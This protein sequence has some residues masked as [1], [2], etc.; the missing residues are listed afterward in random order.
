MATCGRCQ[1]EITWAW[2][3]SDH[4]LIALDTSESYEG[5][6]YTLEFEGPDQ[7]PQASPV[8]RPGRFLGH[9]LHDETCGAGVVL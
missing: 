2:S 8:R 4:A 5:R 3:E 6:T 1:R 9:R 7:R